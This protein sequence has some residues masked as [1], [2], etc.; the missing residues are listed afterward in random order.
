MSA[1][2][3]ITYNKLIKSDIVVDQVFFSHSSQVLSH[4]KPTAWRA[5]IFAVSLLVVGLFGR[6]HRRSPFVCPLCN[7]KPCVLSCAHHP[8]HSRAQ[9][10]VVVVVVVNLY[11][12]VDQI[13]SVNRRVSMKIDWVVA[14]ATVWHVA[15][16]VK[17]QS[18]PFRNCIRWMELHACVLLVQCYK[19]TCANA[20][21]FHVHRRHLPNALDAAGANVVTIECAFCMCRRCQS[22]SVCWL[23]VCAFDVVT[24][25]RN[26]WQF[27]RKQTKD[28]H[29]SDRWPI[30]KS[31]Q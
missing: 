10:F 24:G 19:C 4:W 9:F 1:F 20:K 28:D 22:D 21:C 13:H 31:I 16:C 8:P 14:H 25:D 15:S 29:I 30:R 5:C 2:S 26:N 6:H 3:S 11:G 23:Y 7:K 18:T 17:T 27:W 12:L